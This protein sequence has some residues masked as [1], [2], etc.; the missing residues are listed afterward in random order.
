[1]DP[2]AYV[3]S[4]EV[5]R[6]TTQPQPQ[7]TLT[8]RLDAISERAGGNL[9]NLASI[10]NALRERL[11]VPPTP[12]PGPAANGN[13]LPHQPG[14]DGVVSLLSEQATATSNVLGE[15]E[16]LVSRL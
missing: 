6:P 16:A 15:L 1:M 10:T 4:L 5:A 2:R 14:L 13:K 9:N 3:A 12:P 7:P 8:T 11:G